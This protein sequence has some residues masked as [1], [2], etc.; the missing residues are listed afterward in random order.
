MCFLDDILITGKDD[1]E[2]L[3]RLEQVLKKIKECGL[4]VARDKCFFFQ[5]SVKYLEH[6]ID[7]D[8]LHTD[9]ERIEAI[10]KI[11][12]PASV[13][14]LKSFLGMVNFYAKFIPNASTILKPLY[15]LL[16]NDT[17]WNWSENCQQSFENIKKCLA[18]STVLTHFNPQL[19]VNLTVDASEVGLGA[20]ISNTSDNKQEKP[21]A[22]A[23]RLLSSAES[24]YSQIE[25]EAAAIIFGIQ[26]IFQYLYGRKFCLFTDHKPLLTIFS[27]KK[28]MATNFCS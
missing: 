13:T 10:S 11:N 17:S 22:F 27:P 4:K 12:S 16:K 6:I 14:Q 23:S 18:S 15:N 1:Q 9:K 26:K 3:M 20:I 28:G 7:K 24:K 8:G 5:D 2:H 21:I 25:K 19:Q